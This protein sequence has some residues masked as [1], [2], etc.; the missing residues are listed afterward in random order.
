M[1]ECVRR[2]PLETGTLYDEDR[3]RLTHAEAALSSHRAAMGCG[4]V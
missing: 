4:G 1:A 3:E 2:M